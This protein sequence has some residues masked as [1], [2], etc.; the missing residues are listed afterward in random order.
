M[1]SCRELAEQKSL[2]PALT[3]VLEKGE[4]ACWYFVNPQTPKKASLALDAK[5]N[6]GDRTL[7][8]V[9][10]VFGVIHQ[11][12]TDHAILTRITQEVIEDF[13]ADNVQY[14][15]LRTTP[16]VLHRSVIKVSSL[17]ACDGLGGLASDQCHLRL[18]CV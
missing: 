10:Q 4:T 12:T 9:F 5:C 16:K 17:H 3:R 1:T 11:V 15:E 6:A 18:L 14:L 8:E 7:S 13:A 2:D